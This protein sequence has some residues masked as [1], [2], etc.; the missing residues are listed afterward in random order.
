MPGIADVPV[1]LFVDGIFDYLPVQN[2]LSFGATNRFFH[3][4]VN[5]ESLWH[6]R[7]Q[8]DFNF[9]GAETARHTGWKFLYKRLSNPTV[10]VWGY[11]SRPLCIIQDEHN[12]GLL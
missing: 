7:I 11:V 4:I 5:D 12:S 6:K 10:Y 2:L 9:S 8:Q 3:T 1:E